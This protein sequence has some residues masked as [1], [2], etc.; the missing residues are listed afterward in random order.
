MTKVAVAFR[1]WAQPR[2]LKRLRE[3]PCLGGDPGNDLAFDGP[4]AGPA[5][6]PSAL[7]RPSP[8]ICG[9]W[10]K[11]IAL[12]RV[13][14]HL[15]FRILP[16]SDRSHGN[17]RLSGILGDWLSRSNGRIPILRIGSRVALQV[18]VQ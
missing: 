16:L 17:T 11:A 3:A 7:P 4:L 2:R 5:H 10:T 15:H 14:K 1:L 6:S 9:Y 12:P 18:K 13:P 8:V